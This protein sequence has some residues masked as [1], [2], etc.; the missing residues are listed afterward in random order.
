[1][2][3]DDIILIGSQAG[4]NVTTGGQSIMIGRQAGLYSTTGEGNLLIGAES[5]L[6]NTKG[7][8]NIGIGYQSLRNFDN[9]KTS[10]D[11]GFNIAIGYQTAKNLGDNSALGA[12][13]LSFQNTI[14]GYQALL[15]GDTSNNNVIIGSQTAMNVDNKRLFANNILVGTEAGKTANLSVDSI[16]IGP[17]ANKV[18]SGC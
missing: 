1:M 7:K 12:Y 15:N 3:A 6:Q 4:S 11:G 17:N 2:Y 13:Q 18:G 14:I 9:H 5:G 10:G 16:I 8:Y